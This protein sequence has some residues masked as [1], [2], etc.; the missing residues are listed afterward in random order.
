MSHTE[1]LF[2]HPFSCIVAGPSKAGKTVFASK[3]LKHI[4]SISTAKPVEIIWAFAEYQPNYKELTC[5]PRVRLCQGIPALTEL[6]KDTTQPKLVV[7]DDLMTDF[8]K[9]DSLVQL[10]TRGVHHW[11]ISCIHI[12]QNLFFSGQ[13]TARVN[14]HYMVLFKN[15]SDKLQVATLGRQLYPQK[16]KYFMEA[17]QD[18]TDKP[19]TYLLVD[20]SQG[21]PDELRLRTNIFPGEVQIVYVP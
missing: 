20:M 16:S 7:F 11:N 14:A 15:P 18:A 8:K 21:C 5:I 10:F 19:H 9:D 4:D 13:R 2:Q 17:F 6:R 12:V 3:F 1:Q